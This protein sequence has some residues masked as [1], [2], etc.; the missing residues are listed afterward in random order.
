MRILKNIF[1]SWLIGVVAIAVAA[2]AIAWYCKQSQKPQP[3]LSASGTMQGVNGYT[4]A[5]SGWS[6]AFTA[7]AT[8]HLSLT[9]PSSQGILVDFPT[10]G[11]TNIFSASWTPSDTPMFVPPNTNWSPAWL[12]IGAG[13]SVVIE[14]AT[15]G[16]ASSGTA[17]TGICVNVW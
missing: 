16:A 4:T 12:T 11:P 3:H 7:N 10:F 9:D 14:P 15:N 8:G 6:N 5:T 1:G 17:A 13:Q 2:V